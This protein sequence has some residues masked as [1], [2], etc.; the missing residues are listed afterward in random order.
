MSK[1]E[2][3]GHVIGSGELSV[4]EHRVSHMSN[5][6]KPQTR[7][8]L[9]A[10]L[11]AIGNYRQF[12]GGFQRWSSLLTPHTSKSSPQLVLWTPQMEGAFLQLKLSLCN[13]SALCVPVHDDV[14]QLETD[15]SSSGIGAVLSVL[16]DSVWRP[17][18]FFSKQLQGAQKNYSAKEL[19]G[20]ALYSAIL[21]FSFYLYGRA[22]TVITDH[23]PL[24]TLMEGKQNN[25]RLL[26]WSMKLS[27]FSFKVI[28]RPGV[29]NQPA[30]C[31]SRQAWSGVT[32][33]SDPEPSS[34]EGQM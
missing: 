30:D 21:H 7:K 5:Y 15:A 11:G 27:E 31:L 33:E 8:Q 13:V 1:L 26:N 20:L 3:L 12:V 18:S 25:K 32:K 14:F 34:K 29:M 19:E 17:S 28:Y 6:I 24:E 23:K 10:F 16:R 9:R 2:Y 4:P 22:F